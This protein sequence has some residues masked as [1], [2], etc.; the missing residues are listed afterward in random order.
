VAKRF[1]SAV[2]FIGCLLGLCVSARAVSIEQVQPVM[3]EI[4]VYVHTDGEDLSSIGASDIEATL[5]GGPLS[6]ESLAPSDEGIFYIFMFDISRSI[7]QKHLDAAKAAV[8]ST[9]QGLRSQD[10]MAVITFGNEVKTL[11]SGG[12]SAEQV[13]QAVSALQCTDDNTHFYD[14]MDTL[15]KTA[16]AKTDLRNIAVVVSDGMEDAQSGMTQAQLEQTLAQSGI[17]VYALAVDS[18]PA[19]ALETFRNFIHVSGGELYVFSPENAGEMLGSL[20]AKV[21]ETWSLSLLADSNIAD[22]QQHTLAVKFGGLGSV[23]A[24]ICPVKWIP[25]D[26]APTIVSV[27][28][29]YSAE[30]VT[31]AFSEAMDGLDDMSRYKL[32]GADGKTLPLSLGAE[33][34]DTVTLSAKGLSGGTGWKLTFSGLTDASMEKNPLPERTVELAGNAAYSSSAP[35]S[36]APAVSSSQAPA[37]AKEEGDLRSAKQEVLRAVLIIAGVVAVAAAAAVAAVAAARHRRRGKD[38]GKAET[39]KY[40]AEKQTVRFFFDPG[41]GENGKDHTKK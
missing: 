1:L 12:E 24:Q 15:V 26:K 29:D 22:G 6:V 16:A 17:A 21:G 8:L 38:G 14:A 34:A 30:T 31:A 5:D 27:S 7:S 32:S 18:S 13:N 41:A 35:Q 25:D 20:L 37:A 28:A 2:L 36:S 11:L 33:T 39:K 23:S 40:P 19:A 10:Q 4:S 9:F 3:P